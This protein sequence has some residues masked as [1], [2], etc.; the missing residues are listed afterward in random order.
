MVDYKRVVEYIQACSHILEK[1]EKIRE[2][3]PEGY[4][5]PLISVWNVPDIQKI[6]GGLDYERMN[7]LEENI[8]ILSKAKLLKELSKEIFLA[9]KYGEGG[10]DNLPQKK[11]MEVKDVRIRGVK[12]PKYYGD[13]GGKRV[14]VVFNNQEPALGDLEILEGKLVIKNGYYYLYIKTYTKT[15]DQG[16][17]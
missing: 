9:E 16:E 4:D 5:E 3:I 2:E 13:F 12:D 1:E 7:E 8:R 15:L 14:Q 17:K 11:T 6:E 10:G